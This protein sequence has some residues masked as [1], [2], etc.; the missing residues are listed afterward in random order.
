VAGAVTD[1]GERLSPRPF[2][3]GVVAEEHVGSAGEEILGNALIELN[4]EG[5]AD[6]VG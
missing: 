1:P 2:L 3:D 4:A 5:G 6:D